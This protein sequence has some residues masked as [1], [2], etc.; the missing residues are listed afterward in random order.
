[1]AEL[2]ESRFGTGVTGPVSDIPAASR[3]LIL[4]EDIEARRRGFR[5]EDARQNFARRLKVPTKTLLHIRTQR[6]KSI[7]A[8]L[9]NGIR[10]LLINVLQ[11]EIAKLEDE[12]SIARK[13]GLD[14][15]TDDLA[16]AASAIA[17]ARILLRGE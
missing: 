9:M 10:D 5:V 15:R 11:S 7:P 4:A 17:A 6:R 3:M 2:E 1:M 13:V 16:K 8:F 12:I 14:D